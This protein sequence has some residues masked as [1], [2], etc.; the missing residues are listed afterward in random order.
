MSEESENR[1]IDATAEEYANASPVRGCGLANGI[2]WRTDTG[3]ESETVQVDVLVA[4]SQQWDMLHPQ[5]DSLIKHG[6]EGVDRVLEMPWRGCPVCDSQVAWRQDSVQRSNG[7][8]RVHVS[9]D[10][11][12]GFHQRTSE[13]HPVD[14]FTVLV[15]FSAQ[16]DGCREAES[17][18][19]L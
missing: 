17:P 1:A 18:P 11:K 8:L 13:A 7:G 12:A 5:P 4:H 3:V 2:M 14:S 19:I 9:P 16:D 15:C 10:A 6:R